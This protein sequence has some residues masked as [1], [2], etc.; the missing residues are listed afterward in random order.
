MPR[1][2]LVPCHIDKDGKNLKLNLGRIGLAFLSGQCG[3]EMCLYHVEAR[4][5]HRLEQLVVG[6]LIGNRLV[7][8]LKRLPVR[9]DPE[10]VMA[11][12]QKFR[13]GSQNGNAVEF[14]G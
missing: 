12:L 8:R 14:V 13:Q 3:A 11:L 1:E 7:T 2:L 6:S 4:V 5:Q 9:H 10:T